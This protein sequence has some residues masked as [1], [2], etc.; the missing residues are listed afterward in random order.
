MRIPEGRLAVISL[1]MVLPDRRVIMS[2]G[3]NVSPWSVTKE[4]PVLNLPTSSAL[5]MLANFGINPEDR[6]LG[7]LAKE[8]VLHVGR[9]NIHPF[10]YHIKKTITIRG[11]ANEEFKA[12]PWDSLVDDLTREAVLQ[13]T[14]MQSGDYT[15]ASVYSAAKL[16]SEGHFTI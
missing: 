7:T 14:G 2:K 8:A 10:A 12:V 4:A 3:G 6:E 9:I 11:A 13:E 5:T 1:C 16:H 15:M